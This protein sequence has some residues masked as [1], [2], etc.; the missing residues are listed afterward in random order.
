MGFWQSHTL[1]WRM[2]CTTLTVSFCVLLLALSSGPAI[3]DGYKQVVGPSGNVGLVDANGKW[4]YPAQYEA[5]TTQAQP[6][7]SALWRDANGGIVALQ[8]GDDGRLSERR[9]DSL[10]A[11]PLT[12][13][14]FYVVRRQ[15]KVGC[16]D[17]AGRETLAPQFDAIDVIGGEIFIT[18]G[19]AKG[20]LTVDA[21]TLRI[22]VPAMYDSIENTP[23]WPREVVQAGRHGLIDAQGRA[24]IPVAFDYIDPEPGFPR[25]VRLGKAWGVFAAPTAGNGAV[26]PVV[27]VSYDEVEPLKHRSGI[28]FKVRK[29]A[30]WGVLSPSGA[31]VLAVAFDDV[32]G[33]FGDILRAKSGDQKHYHTLDGKTLGYFTS[34]HKT[35]VSA[36]TAIIAPAYVQTAEPIDPQIAKLAGKGLAFPWQGLVLVAMPA[37]V[38]WEFVANMRADMVQSSMGVFIA[39]IGPRRIDISST[40]HEIPLTL[41][42]RNEGGEWVIVAA[43]PTDPGFCGNGHLS[44]SLPPGTQRLTLGPRFA[45]THK[46]KFRFA[47]P[48]GTAGNGAVTNAYSNEFDSTISPQRLRAG[49][50]PPP[51]FRVA[52]MPTQV[53]L[54]GAGSSQT[55]TAP[56]VAAPFDDAKRA[57]PTLPQDKREAMAE[58]LLRADCKQATA[59]FRTRLRGEDADWLEGLA[60]TLREP[61]APRCLS[62]VL[63]LATFM[64]DDLAQQFAILA[65]GAQASHAKQLAPLR[66]LVKGPDARMGWAAAMTKLKDPAQTKAFGRLLRA[67][68]PD[69]IQ[70]HAAMFRYV[71]RPELV[72]LLL[73]WF[74]RTDAVGAI[75]HGTFAPGSARLDPTRNYSIADVATWLCRDMGLVVDGLK[76]GDL[77][78]WAAGVNERMKKLVEAK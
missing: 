19:H 63:V 32:A 49:V 75:N 36:P 64:K 51:E 45:G 42:A 26:R 53:V 16:L 12:N 62:F 35:A 43:P 17:S 56:T 55:S 41:Q 38:P 14:P 37:M 2:R 40:D 29:G 27:A 77:P 72:G 52:S 24:L 8:Q 30:L 59:F 9:Y 78:P 4:L 5:I 67:A 13:F 65:A 44:E 74:T 10:V 47:L 61:D 54:A 18:N 11:R 33:F 73:P 69:D 31:T 1:Q 60:V 7:F 76:P 71:N 39:N 15:N 20:M 68:A 66:S 70:E 6:R 23:S 25:R 50:K 58:A 3:A 22:S 28:Y 34:Q 46:T 57:W 21:G 48:V